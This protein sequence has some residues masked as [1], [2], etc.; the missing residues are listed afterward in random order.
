MGLFDRLS[1]G[2]KNKKKEKGGSDESLL[3]YSGMRVEVLDAEGQMLFTARLSVSEGGLVQLYQQSDGPAGEGLEPFPVQLRGYHTT[4]NKAVHMTGTAFWVSDGLWRVDQF[5]V[6]GKDNDRA[7]YRQG[8]DTG[9]ELVR[10]GSLGS[11]PAASCEVV[12]ISVGG[13]CVRTD[14]E[15]AAG[16]RVLLRSRLLPNQNLAPLICEVKRISEKRKGQFE[17]GCQFVDLNPAQ[18]DQIAKAILELQ[19]QRIRR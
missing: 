9:G 14:R 13:V 15:F 17:Y 1:G 19:R 16:D 5:R 11:E 6:T 2:G 12:N 7:Y 3:D 10:L 4:Q 18:E 8:I